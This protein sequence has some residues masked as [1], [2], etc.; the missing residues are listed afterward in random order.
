MRVTLKGLFQAAAV[1]T[2]VFSVVTL[3]PVDHHAV[4]LFTHFRLQYL[5]A[6]VILL[7]VL[8]A[9]HEP[10][11]AI[12][13]ALAA[14]LNA[15]SVLPWY[16]DEPTGGTGTEFK[17]L[18]ANV[19][20]RNED[21]APLLDLIEAEQPDLVFLIE[22]TPSWAESL[23][24]L[25]TSY[26]HSIVEPRNGTFGIAMFTRLPMTSAAAVDS[27]P[28]AFPTIV[29]TLEV[30]GKSLNVVATHPMIPL[31]KANHE[32]RN[33]QLDGVA[34]LLQKSGGARLLAGDLN[35]TMW[36]SEYAALENR[37]WLRNARQGFGLLPTWPTFFPPAM[38]PIDHLLVS[39]EIGVT[40]F[41]TGPRIG[42]DHL[43]LIATLTL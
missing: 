33:R 31:G 19:L 5:G 12:A 24:R 36:D 42:S 15:N 20:A 8:G 3:L 6:S 26:A 18:L 21:H 29:A 43:P 40:E 28:L 41:R 30:G 10:R 35:V 37:T 13:M 27:S 1:L 17:V 22:V 7:L 34:R 25:S 2:L 16:F 23:T 38:I 32:A 39:D 11:Y 14:A 9:W 4:Q